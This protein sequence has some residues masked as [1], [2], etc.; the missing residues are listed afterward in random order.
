MEKMTDLTPEPLECDRRMN[1]D[2]CSVES[3]IR[4]VWIERGVITIQNVFE[5]G[6]RD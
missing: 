3:G 2:L 4:L 5:Y 1:L 6:E